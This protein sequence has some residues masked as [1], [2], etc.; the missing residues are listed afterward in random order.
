MQINTNLDAAFTARQLSGAE[1]TLTRA[2]RRLSSGLRINSAADDAAGLAISERMTG[3]IRGSRQA[4]RNANDGISLL[5]TADGSLS[6]VSDALQRI[7]ELSVQAANDTNSSS[8]RQALQDEAR[9]LVQEISRMGETAEF[10]GEKIFSQSHSSIGGDPNKRAVLDGMRIGWLSSSE[11][12]IAQY[13]G[14]QGGGEKMYIGVSS[15]TDGPGNI[16]AFV[17]P[18]SQPGYFQDLQVDMADATPANLPNGGTYPFYTDRTVMHEMVHAVMNSAITQ[19]VPT[20]FKEGSAEFIHGADERLKIDI[21]AAGGGAAGM[22]AVVGSVNGAGWASDSQHY[23]GAYVKV[24]YLHDQL[25]AAGAG[26]IKGLMQYLN[27]NPG[28][29]LDTALQSLIGK[30]LATFESDFQANGVA[31]IQNRINLTNA[32]TG[33]VGGLDAD[34]GPEQTAD[35]IVP[36]GGGKGYDPNDVLSGFKETFENLGG[37]AGSRQVSFQIGAKAGENLQVELGAVNAFALGIDDTDLSTGAGASVSI[38]HVDEALAYVNKQ[39][40]RIGAQLSRLET[41]VT[42]LQSSEQN[43]IASRSRI[44]DTDYAA[45]TAGLA[46]SQILQQAAGGLIAQTKVTGQLVLGLLRA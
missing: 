3:Q 2:Y 5:Q 33:A 21:A 12:R 7:R 28:S 26:G 43:L 39:R 32:D 15:F 22:A 19:S 10:N 4:A 6:S 25:K 45:E 37:G 42:N 41:A 14:I 27:K 46:R 40:A 34:G 31:Y 1:N 44:Q 36:F 11:T 38:V 13:Y 24:R 16:A 23:S 17:G 35:S 9:Q 20:W 30:N 8:D 29:D 18:P